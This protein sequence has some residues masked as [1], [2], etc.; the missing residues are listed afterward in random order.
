MTTLRQIANEWNLNAVARC[1]QLDTGHDISYSRVLSPTLLRV[2]GP[3]RG[4]RVLDVGCGCGVLAKAAA[5]QAQHVLGIDISR[6]M[7]RQSIKRTRGIHNLELKTVSVETFSTISRQRFDICLA[8]MSLMTMP[9]LDRALAAIFKLL[10][11]TGLLVASIPHPCF[12]N[13]YRQDEPLRR[14]NYWTA[15]PVRAPFRISLDQNPLPEPTTYFHRPLSNY[16]TTILGQG[17][18]LTSVIEPAPP[19]RAPK[20]YTR[21]FDLP[22]FL[23]LAANKQ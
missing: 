18:S 22:R 14:F 23:V 13:F 20:V 8:N 3:L 2:A 7:I 21:A 16:I 4:K 10:K 12:W 11:P 15:H 17:F 5:R 6:E 19:R 1:Q 9:R